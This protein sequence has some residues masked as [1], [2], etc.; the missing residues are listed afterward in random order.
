VSDDIVTR[1]EFNDM[2][3]VVSEIKTGIKEKDRYNAK[4][5]MGMRDSKIRTEIKLESIIKSQEVFEVNQTKLMTIIQEIHDKP[6]IQWNKI[7]NAWKTGIG[8]AVI[9]T[10]VPYILGN[11]LTFTKMFGN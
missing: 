3:V 4:E 9:G 8:L 2:K 6:F 11:Y 5:M 10:A 7:T 1:A